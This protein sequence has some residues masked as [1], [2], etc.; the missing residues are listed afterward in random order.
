MAVPVAIEVAD[1]AEGYDLMRALAVR[2]LIAE[3]RGDSVPLEV[4]I[5]LR[6]EPTELLLADLLPAL[7]QFRRDRCRAPIPIRV[8]TRR[9][10]IAGD[11]AVA[12]VLSKV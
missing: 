12:L 8:G 9:S 3:L 4:T 7:A 11:D 5:T 6:H 10:A 2:G 1:E